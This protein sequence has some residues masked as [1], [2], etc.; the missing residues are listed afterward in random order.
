MEK[1]IETVVISDEL[2]K[3]YS[4]ISF[5][6]KEIKIYPFILQA[7]NDLKSLIGK[8]LVQDLVDKIE[9]KTLNPYDE[10]L[11][12]KIAPYMATMTYYYALPSLAF[13]N[14]Q[15]GITKEASENST[16]ASLD[17]LSWLRQD[18]KNQADRNAEILLDYLCDCK[19]LYPLFV[20]ECGCGSKAKE[21]HLIYF[22][23]RKHSCGC[24]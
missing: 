12:I 9:A 3:A 5:N 17:E 20:G 23:H 6:T 13:Q 10:A 15:K 8:D 4:P 16:S 14:S 7:Q 21:S 11:L 22:P 18:V 19:E 24:E 2:L 1:I